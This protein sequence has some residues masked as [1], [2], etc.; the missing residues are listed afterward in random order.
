MNFKKA[1]FMAIFVSSVLISTNAFA[2]KYRFESVKGDSKKEVLLNGVG[3]IDSISGDELVINDSAYVLKKS[4]PINVIE[5]G[6][7]YSSAL[8]EGMH[9][10][11]VLDKDRKLSALWIISNPENYKKLISQD[12][13]DDTKKE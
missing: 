3:V 8:K 4:I 9:V 2:W 13:G 11:I 5:D 7:V 10:G 6:S 1:A 12:S